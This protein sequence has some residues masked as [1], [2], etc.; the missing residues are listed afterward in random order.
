M[1]IVNNLSTR[2]T[3]G[4]SSGTTKGSRHSTSQTL[5]SNSSPASLPRLSNIRHSNGSSSGTSNQD[6]NSYDQKKQQSQTTTTATTTTQP[7]V[8]SDTNK[9]TTAATTTTTDNSD[10]QVLYR[11]PVWERSHQILSEDDTN[12]PEWDK[13]ISYIEELVSNN[14]NIFDLKLKNLLHKEFN[15]LLTRFPLL[16]DYWKKYVAIEYTLNGLDASLKILETSLNSFPNSLELWLDYMSIIT[17]NNTHDSESIRVLYKDAINKTGRQFLSHPIWDSYLDWEL[18]ESGENSNEYINIILKVIKIPLHQYAKY[19]QIFYKLKDNFTIEDLISKD[20]LI[21][22]RNE[23]SNELKSDSELINIYFDRIFTKIENGTNTRWEFESKLN[24][25]H[26]DLNLVPYDEIIN[27]ENYLNFEE[28]EFAKESENNNISNIEQVKSLYERSLI[29]LAINENL[30][31]KYVNWLIKIYKS[32]NIENQ[33]ITKDYI[34]SIFKRGCDSFIPIDQNKLRYKFGKFCEICKDY[35][36]SD[37]IYYN[38]IKRFPSEYEP[39]SQIFKSFLR[40]K[41]ETICIKNSKIIINNFQ[42]KITTNKEIKSSSSSSSSSNSKHRDV[43][44]AK[45]TESII[46]DSDFKKLSSYLNERNISQLIVEISKILW[47]RQRKVKETRD[48]LVLFFKEQFIKSSIT[49]WN[50]FFK[51]ELQQRNKKNLTNIINYIKLYS[52]LPISIINNLIKLYIEF[53]FKNSNKLELFNISREIERMLLEIDDESS[54]NMKRFLKTRLDSGRDEEVTNKRLIKENGHPGISV[55]FK[56]RIVN[57]L[58]FT[59]PIKFNENPVSIPYF[60]NVEKA[61]LP[62]HYPTMEKE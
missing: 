31:I 59:D 14:S 47:I 46:P 22:L 4:G 13:L 9:T 57:A 30:W 15:K 61:T 40:R 39:V 37:S 21:D 54:T 34:K 41:N 11:F 1:D 51:F 19:F 33:I 8:K 10:L 42:I 48:F 27:W 20:Q 56:P 43:I 26:F 32:N 36:E 18:K 49:Y 35:E 7:Q 52:N 3:S 29:P 6:E 2:Q 62:I 53:L 45:H 16:V 50:F 23:D 17:S 60:T 38:I 44:E 5:N 12:L 24:K 28:K 58:N 25:Q 55:E